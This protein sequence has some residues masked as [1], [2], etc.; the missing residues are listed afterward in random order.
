MKIVFLIRKGNEYLFLKNSITDKYELPFIECENSKEG[1]KKLVGCIKE[2]EIGIEVLENNSNLSIS[3]EVEVY[4]ASV[5]YY[6]SNSKGKWVSFEEMNLIKFEEWCMYICNALVKKRGVEL[7]IYNIIKNTISDIADNVGLHIDLVETE[8]AITVFIVSDD[9]DYFPYTFTL[10]YTEGEKEEISLNVVMRVSRMFAPGEKSDLY[11]LFANTM[12]IILKV[13]FNDLAESIYVGHIVCPDEIDGA[14]IILSQSLQDIGMKDLLNVVFSIFEK[15]LAAMQVHYRLFGS[16]GMQ[17]EKI[18]YADLNW[19]LKDVKIDNVIK[20]EDHK[21][22]INYD[23]GISML[24]LSEKQYR[25]QLITSIH[26]WEIIDGIDGKIIVQ[27]EEA[28]KTYNLIPK[29]RW[30]YVQKIL[31]TGGCTSYDIVC[32]ENK[33]YVLEANRIWI[34][35][36]EYYHYWVEEETEKIFERQ[37]KENE[38]LFF[39]RNFKWKYPIKSSR[40]EELI[41]DLLESEPRVCKVRL[42]GKSN[43]SDGGRD[44]LIY[45]MDFNSE[46]QN[47]K[48][49]LVIGQCKAYKHSVNKSHVTDIRDM[50]ENYN[51]YGFVLAVASEL[52]VPLIDNLNKLSERYEVDWWTERE[53]FAKLRRNYHLIER[54]KD[55]V[56]VM[57]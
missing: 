49:Y 20:R 28:G 37:K 52:T 50:L 30:E 11:V 55:I 44:I 8:S 25:P 48:M 13:V 47:D 29:Q 4:D 56:E 7:K 40:F 53:I 32:Q 19:F 2:L 51:A 5:F 31:E 14:I 12:N 26:K 18:T 35:E 34:L 3:D 42:M 54:Y 21:Y 57:E 43:N 38:I 45:K 17:I 16:Y 10:V 41:A 27:Y 46:P 15:F 23:Q 36:G 22:F 9:N 24:E 1:I 6:T 33:L 39:N